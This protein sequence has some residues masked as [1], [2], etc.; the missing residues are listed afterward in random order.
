MRSG[1]S[2]TLIALAALAG[3]AGCSSNHYDESIEY[4]VR[5]D[6]IVP[7]PSQWGDLVPPGFNRPG[8]LPLDA[9]KLPVLR[10]NAQSVADNLRR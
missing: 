3:A 10:R 6:L 5:T 4:P 2:L 7:K 9:L 1:P 8:L